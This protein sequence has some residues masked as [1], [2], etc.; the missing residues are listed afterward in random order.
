MQKYTHGSFEVS[1]YKIS[2]TNKDLKSQ[3]DIGAAWGKFMSEDFVNRIK[4]KEF[5]GVHVVY[6]NYTNPENASERGYDM[7]IGFL[8]KSGEAQDDPE[9]TTLEIPALNYEYLEVK[10]AMPTCVID[11][12]QKINTMTP[13]ECH[14]AFAYDLDMYAEDRS[15]A[16]LTVSVN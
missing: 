9:I 1:G 3:S 8:T 16:T 2:T 5:P 13:D 11:G 12:W 4:H 14:R 7:I 6:F 10:G 15:G